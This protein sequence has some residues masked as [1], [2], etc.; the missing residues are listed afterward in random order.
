MRPSESC[1]KLLTVLATGLGCLSLEPAKLTSESVPYLSTLSRSTLHQ[2]Q[3][4]APQYY[5]LNALLYK[6]KPGAVQ[7]DG[8]TDEDS[9]SHPRRPQTS[10]ADLRPGNRDEAE[11]NEGSSSLDALVRSMQRN[12]DASGTSNSRFN[13]DPDSSLAPTPRRS[14]RP[15]SMALDGAGFLE[16]DTLVQKR[17]N[18]FAS[19]ADEDDY[20]A[21]ANGSARLK[22]RGEF[23][24]HISRSSFLCQK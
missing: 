3:S 24:K 11:S 17:T 13:D 7:T 19:E 18:S 20:S 8:H 23:M 9:Q 16:D 12:K 4:D 1:L 10:V 5:G 2:S 15:G 6:S 22:N 21:Q 14:G